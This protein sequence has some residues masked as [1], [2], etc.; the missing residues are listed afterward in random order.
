MSCSATNTIYY[1]NVLNKNS[2][3]TNLSNRR[4]NNT[5]EILD[6]LYTRLASYIGTIRT[7]LYEYSKGNFYAV[8]NILT[9]EVYNR[10]STELLSLAVNPIKYPNYETFRVTY[11]SALEGLYQSILQYSLLVDTNVKI[12]NLQYYK[13]VL[14]DPKKLK[15]YIESLKRSNK[16]FDDAVV[17]IPKAG[18][19]PQYAEYIKRHGFPEGGVFEMD[20]LADIMNDLNIAVN[21]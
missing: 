4:N 12:D 7:L 6:D 2:V 21:V 17:Q 16:V 5:C 15:D 13:D 19:K 14:T 8:A 18:I 10:M 1:K 3:I 9:R 11:T 20:K